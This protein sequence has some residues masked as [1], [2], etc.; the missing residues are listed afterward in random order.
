V[1]SA[2]ADLAQTDVHSLF[3]DSGN[4]SKKQK[5]ER[6]FSSHQPLLRQLFLSYT[7]R[8][9]KLDYPESLKVARLREFFWLIRYSFWWTPAETLA[10]TVSLISH[11]NRVSKSR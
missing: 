10:I 3:D 1:K 7:T 2:P 4:R 8:V 11:K 9:T 6:E 5:G